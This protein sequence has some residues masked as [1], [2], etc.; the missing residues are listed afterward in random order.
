MMFSNAERWDEC[1][2]T[3]LDHRRIG[4]SDGQSRP[5]FLPAGSET[6]QRPFSQLVGDNLVK[7]QLPV[8]TSAALRV[9]MCTQMTT[10]VT[11]CT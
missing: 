7:E 8:A 5:D 10:V 2:I 9:G 1:A 6:L 4:R 3:V 11:S